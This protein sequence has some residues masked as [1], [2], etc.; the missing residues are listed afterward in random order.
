[1][2]MATSHQASRGSRKAAKVAR[3]GRSFL[4]LICANTHM[5]RQHA[6]TGSLCEPRTPTACVEPAGTLGPTPKTTT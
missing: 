4:P 6:A 3:A 2:T 1:M 5:Y